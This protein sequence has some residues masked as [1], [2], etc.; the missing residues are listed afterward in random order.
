M[1]QAPTETTRT[2]TG[3]APEH[4]AMG[5]RARIAG[6]F[7]AILAALLVVMA[8]SGCASGAKPAGAARAPSA[9]ATHVLAT[10]TPGPGTPTATAQERLFATVAAQAI[11]NLVQ[12]M[13]V[14]YDAND[15][16]VV[17]SVVV[18]GNVPNTDATISVAQ[19][20]VK[21]ICFRAQQALWTSGTA[22][23][24]VTIAISGPILDQYAAHINGAYGAALLTAANAA[25]FVW[26][27][28]TPD[29]AWGKYDSVFLRPD[30]NDAS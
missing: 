21:T 10:S 28:L 20:Q 23:S 18:G 17:V 30:Y 8:A 5:R 7:A 25:H 29:A 12:D 6:V 14:T 22:F 1:R 19:E 11:G 4:Q 3:N 2:T 15:R 26:S 27:S 24:K 9:T 13:Q 16:S